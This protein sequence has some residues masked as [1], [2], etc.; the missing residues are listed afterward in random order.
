MSKEQYIKVKNLSISENLYKFVNNEIL[1]ETKIT[2]VNFWSGFSKAAHELAKKNKKLLEKREE[3]QI[4]INTYN[5]IRKGKKINIQEY[6]K[7]LYKIGYIKKKGSNFKIKTKNVDDEIAKICGPQLVCPVSNAR[8]LLNAANAR[9]VSLYDSLYGSDLIESE[10]SASER[11][12]PERGL[13]VI[14]YTKKFLDKYFPLKKDKWSN[15][16]KIKIEKKKI[17]LIT[18]KFT[19]ELK[20]EKKFVGYRGDIESPTAVILK[21]NN[22]HLEIIIN[23][24]AFSAKSDAA[25]ISDIIVESA[26]T[27]ICDNEDSVTAVDAEDKINCYKNWLGLMKKKL[28][29]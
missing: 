27:T 28:N 2:S 20:S 13:E 17:K 25:G 15:I 16:K 10:E 22:L 9:W 24:K 12:D 5:K 29:A 1:P 8:F 3:I 26:L 7:F 4:K 14:R 6:Q 23:P 19:D 21:N 11:Y 18:Y